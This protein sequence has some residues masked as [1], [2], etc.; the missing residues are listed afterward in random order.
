MRVNVLKLFKKDIVLDAQTLG[1]RLTF[2]VGNDFDYIDN[3]RNL[4]VEDSNKLFNESKLD[5]QGDGLKSYVSTFLSLKSTDADILLLDEPEAFLHPPLARQLGELIGE[6][7]TK[8]KQIFVATHSVEILKGILTKCQNV[9]IIRITQPESNNNEIQI[10]DEKILREI[11]KSPLLRVSRVLEGLFCEKVVITEAESDELVYQ[12]LIEKLFPQSGL[13]FVHGQN[14]QTLAEIA[15]L[16]KEI[17]INYEII[18]DFDALRISS[19]LKKFLLLMPIDES[20]IDKNLNYANKMREI[21]NESITTVG[22][23]EKEIEEKQKLKRDEVYH[24]TGISFFESCVQVQIKKTLEKF[25]YN[26]LHI[27]E[28]G[29]LETLLIPYGLNYMDKKEWIGKAVTLIEEIDKSQ[30]TKDSYLYRFLSKVVGNS[31]G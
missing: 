20:E 28:C 11:L 31:K 4:S 19:E 27:L 30:I 21:I 22:L 15:N 1:D 13:H 26:H 18:T 6:S 29:E 24:K 25:S 5:D 7:E 17:G 23:T 8:D 3:V 9:N 12:E 10:V 14:K 16:Y 2:R